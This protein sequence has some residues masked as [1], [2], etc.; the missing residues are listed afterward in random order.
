MV[1]IRTTVC[2]IPGRWIRMAFTLWK[3]SMAVSIFNISIKVRRP[4][5][6]PERPT[7]LLKTQKPFHDTATTHVFVNG[8][9][10][11]NSNDFVSNCLLPL[12]QLIHHVQ[13]VCCRAWTVILWPGCVMKLSHHPRLPILKNWFRIIIY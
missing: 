13:K 11:M 5:K 3:K 8:I 6:A 2:T 7:P 1:S 4:Q 10:A 12:L 9:L